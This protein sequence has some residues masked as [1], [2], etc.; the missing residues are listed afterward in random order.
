M[1]ALPL[2]LFGNRRRLIPTQYWWTQTFLSYCSVSNI[3]WTN[4][5]VRSRIRKTRS[6]RSRH[7][8]EIQDGY[9]TL[10]IYSTMGLSGIFLTTYVLFHSWTDKRFFNFISLKEFVIG[11]LYVIKLS[12][13]NALTDSDLMCPYLYTGTICIHSQ[14]SHYFCYCISMS[15]TPVRTSVVRSL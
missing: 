7:F 6:Q 1:C 4:P 15:S 12:V 8:M 11:I 5:N 10:L 9:K 14:D 2:Y 13:L 3:T